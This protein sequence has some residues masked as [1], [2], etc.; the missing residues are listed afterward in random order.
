MLLSY[1]PAMLA[2][3]PAAGGYGGFKLV[4]RTTLLAAVPVHCRAL[5]P[6]RAAPRSSLARSLRS[7]LARSPLA[8]FSLAARGACTQPRYR[9]PGAVVGGL[10][11]GYMATLVGIREIDA[12]IVRNHA[13]SSSSASSSSS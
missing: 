4:T 9:L 8:L 13:P 5:A 6:R 11:V 10:A 2:L 1:S 12:W 3:P 7:P